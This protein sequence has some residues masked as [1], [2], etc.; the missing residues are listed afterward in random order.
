[1]RLAVSVLRA[2]Q[3]V[4]GDM[5]FEILLHGIDAEATEPCLPGFITEVIGS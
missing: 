3:F 5:I 2:D 1:M 4:P